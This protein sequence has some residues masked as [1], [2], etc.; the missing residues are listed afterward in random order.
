MMQRPTIAIAVHGGAGALSDAGIPAAKA[1]V[2]QAARAGYEVLASGGSAVDAVE[3]ATRVLESLPHFNAGYGSVLTRD[4]TVEMDALICDGDLRAGAVSLVQTTRSAVSLAR[5]VMDKSPHM[6]IAGPAADAFGKA[7]GLE[8]VRN[9]ELITAARRTQLEATLAQGAAPGLYPLAGPEAATVLAPS[10]SASEVARAVGDAAS[11]T[12]AAATTTAE[13]V[14]CA[15]DHDTVG[16]VAVD[17]QGRVAAATSTGGLTG[18]W[19]GRVGDTP[20]L[21]AG[22]FAD[23]LSG[24]CSTTG[25]GEYIIRAALARSVCECYEQASAG[26]ASSA[27]AGPKD[28]AA[29][30]AVGAALTRMQ[31]RVGG[32]GAGLVFV[33]RDGSVGV[34]HSTARMSFAF[35]RGTFASTEAAPATGTGGTVTGTGT[36]TEPEEEYCGVEL[37]ASSAH[38]GVKCK[39]FHG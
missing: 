38:P 16:A 29:Q 27:A 19:R 17:S 2:S 15:G 20:L 30:A 5:A 26:S 7:C 35:A 32:P 18:K 10:A 22:G 14:P 6:F 36:A 1:G 39:V 12:A 24:A 23:K 4:G 3:V 11:T 37:E 9:E 28:A 31:Q 13:T 33:G 25:T 34:G 21:G 8:Q